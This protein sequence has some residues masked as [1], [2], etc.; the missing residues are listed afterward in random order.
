[1]SLERRSVRESMY[2]D[3]LVEEDEEDEESDALDHLQAKDVKA[4]LHGRLWQGIHR[5]D[6]FSTPSSILDPLGWCR[7]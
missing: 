1:M 4:R 2:F 6:W 3:K 7:G 5:R